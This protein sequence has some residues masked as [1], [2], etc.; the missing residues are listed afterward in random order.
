MTRD[1]AS[2]AGDMSPY[3]SAAVSAYGDRV[4]AP[5]QDEAADTT[6]GLGCHLLAR[7]FGSPSAEEP[8]P[9]PLARLV[10]DPDDEDA[11][12]ALRTAV[13]DTLAAD[14]DLASELE[15]MLAGSGGGRGGGWRGGGSRPAPPTVRPAPARPRPPTWP[16]PGNEP[17][18]YHPHRPGVQ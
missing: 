6:V 12:A 9:G 16:L 13:R 8:L 10:A 1:V 18:E 11:Q 14:V 7:M 15:S 2:L 4:L 3:M 5:V 17:P